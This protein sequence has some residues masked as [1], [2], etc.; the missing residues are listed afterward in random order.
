MY[1]VLLSRLKEREK[2]MNLELKG[3][4]LVRGVYHVCDMKRILR[5]SPE[6]V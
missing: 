3:H 2:R 1:R 6:I 4:S 5:E